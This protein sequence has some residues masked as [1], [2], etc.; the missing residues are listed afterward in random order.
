MTSQRERSEADF[1]ARSEGGSRMTIEAGAA[2]A[3]T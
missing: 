1:P 2:I 3:H